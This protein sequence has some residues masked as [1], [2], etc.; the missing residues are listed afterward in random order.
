MIKV[1]VWKLRII[2]F[3]TGFIFI[4]CMV[5]LAAAEPVDEEA[6][7]VTSTENSF[8]DFAEDDSLEDFEE[9]EE[10]EDISIDLS[11]YQSESQE[12]S[13]Y[14]FGGFIKEDLGYSF[15][16][17]ADDIHLSKIRTT[18]NLSADFKLFSDW[19]SK[20][21]WNGFYDYAY[22][23]HG[24]EK[25]NDQVLETNEAE[26]EIRDLF[27][28]G[29]I[30]HWMRFKIGRQIIAW[31]ESD[32]WQI[33]DM[34]NPR[35]SIE[36]GMV[37]LEDARIPITATKL[38]FYL[39]TWEMNLVAFHENRGNKLPAQ[40]SEFDIYQTL[41][42]NGVTIEDE[43][44]PS[45]TEAMIRIFKTFNGGD[46]SF[47]WSDVYDDTPHLDF[48][49]LTIFGNRPIL[50][51]L[52]PRHKRIQTIGFSGNCVTGS[53]LFKTELARKSNTAIAR[54]DVM[55]QVQFLAAT[56]SSVTLTKESN[57]I[58]AWSE[59]DVSQW[60]LGFEYNGFD[61]IT[62]SLEA[63]VD[64]V[65]EYES[66]LTGNDISNKV[67]LNLSHKAFNDLLNTRLV[68]VRFSENGG[69]L[70]RIN[71]DYDLVDALNVSGGI[72]VYEA[73]DTSARLYPYRENDRLFAAIKYSF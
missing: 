32:M 13:F 36:L 57:A 8:E 69:D 6:S 72:V 21:V 47:I 11:A 33:N 30:T 39:N 37:D 59:K 18:V 67:T 73:A 17:K 16:H 44:L 12:S 45:D 23:N 71:I 4:V 46:I 26:S 7:P 54:S 49:K 52:T 29:S 38:S 50:V 31:G 10:F 56:T 3:I 22:E 20:I 60:M 24:R 40:G 41:I 58:A 2:F 19:K 70:G 1:P 68:W 53:W 28:D 48:E 25:F 66:T 63:V 43:E 51:S 42:S 14:T 27:L 65:E 61:D 55:A 64:K 15:E 5:T 35:D 34:A 9:G 62:I